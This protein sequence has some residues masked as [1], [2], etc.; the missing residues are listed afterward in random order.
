MAKKELNPI[1]LAVVCVVV[2]LGVAVMYWRGL[3]VEGVKT[4]IP[5]KPN[6]PGAGVGLPAEAGSGT[7]GSGGRSAQ[8]N[9]PPPSQQ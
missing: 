9:V 7:D 6:P 2:I 3:S 1:V 8:P 4:D 5:P